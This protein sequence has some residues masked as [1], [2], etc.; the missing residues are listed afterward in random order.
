MMLTRKPLLLLVLFSLLFSGQAFSY[1][2]AEAD[3]AVMSLEECIETA[4]SRHPDLAAGRADLVASEARSGQT[5]AGSYPSIGFSTGFTERSSTG[6][7]SSEGSWSS[8]ITLSQLVSDWGR[9]HASLKR[10]LLD[11]EG[12]TLELEAIRS[13]I[14]FEVTRSYFQLLKAGKDLEVAEETLALNDERLEQAEA[15]FRVGR[16]SRYDVTAAQVSRS[17]AN[18]ALI[19]ART[20]RKEAMTSLKV[21]MGF[22]DAPDFGIAGFEDDPGDLSQEDLPALERA[23]EFALGNRPDLLS[24]K[25]SLESAENS[26]TLARLDNAPQLHLSGSY[27]WGSSGF[28]G[29]DT[30]RT[31]ITLSFPLYDG[32][33]QREKTREAKANLDG[34]QARLEAY[35]Q[36]V[37]SDVTSAWL[38]A[39]DSTE[40]VAAA[41]EGFRMALENLEIASGRYQVGVGSPLEVSDATRNYTEAKAAWHSALYDGMIA[42]AALEKAMGVTGR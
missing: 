21:A 22:T 11:V 27:G 42:W 33:L 28:W 18:L 6:T 8:A 25:V 41:A 29:Q 31:G 32:G 39:S 15:F 17:N 37:V 36:R 9:T 30:W 7:G 24:Y 10:S 14:V 13:D 26:V 1:R 16:V 35:R 3:S 12:R 5:R 20:S 34:A 4:L 23:I 19:Q 2:L 40:T 38:A